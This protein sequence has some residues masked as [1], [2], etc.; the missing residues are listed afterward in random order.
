MSSLAP[1]RVAPGGRYFETFNGEPLLFIGANDAITWPGLMGLYRRRDVGA[2]EQYLHELAASGVTVLRLM[3][4]YAQDTHHYF[5]HPVGQFN[6]T[7]VQL[8]DDLFTACEEVGLRILLT[9][10]DS[11][12]MDR[13]WEHHP[14]NRANGGPATHSREFFSDETTIAAIERRFQFVV[15]RWGGSGVLAAWDLFNEIHQ[16]WGTPPSQQVAVLTRLSDTI[17]EAEQRAWGFTRPQTVSCFGPNPH[18]D[19]EEMIFQLPCLDFATTHIYA[20]GAMDYPLDTVEPAVVMGRWV[21]YGL[22]HTRLGRPFTDSE[23]GPI[24][25]FNDF[26]EMLPEAF[27]DEY[28]RHLMWAHLASGGAGTGMR[29]PDR[30]PHILTPGMR[31]A[32]ASLRAFTRLVDWRTFSP[33]DATGDITLGATDVLTFACRDAHT[34]V[35][36]LLRGKPEGN[37]PGLMPRHAPHYDVALHLRG[38][39]PGTYLVHTWDTHHQS[40]GDSLPATMR[41][42]GTLQVVLPRIGNDLALAIVRND[43]AFGPG[44]RPV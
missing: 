21:R 43:K 30:Q 16:H 31:R 11:F 7:M 33:Q 42:D 41:E 44:E 2:V 37:L 32:M 19:Y 23:H 17:R 24:H 8:W 36:W 6:P 15:E 20:K 35:I 10:W 28:E 26:H 39:T 40:I 18:P 13:R 3:L 25:L 9:P 14:Y 29:W 1:I 4:E 27:D 34:A 12:W 22:R 5:E 38:L